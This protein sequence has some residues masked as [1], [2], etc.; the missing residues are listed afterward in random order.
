MN[1]PVP[2][3]SSEPA[4][5]QFPSE[6]LRGIA[7]TV[8]KISYPKRLAKL[9]LVLREW[10]QV[11]LAAHLTFYA[12]EVD[13]AKNEPLREKARKARQE[14]LKLVRFPDDVTERA[15]SLEEFP[16]WALAHSILTRTKKFA[17]HQEYQD[18]IDQITDGVLAAAIIIDAA[19]VALPAANRGQP[20]NTAAYLIMQDLEEIF[21]WLTGQRPTRLVNPDGLE[22]G[23]FFEF[24]HRIWVSTYGTAEG[25]Q[26]AIKNW[27]GAKLYLARL[28]PPKSEKSFVMENLHLRH[29]AWGL[30]DR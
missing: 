9:E 3:G 15:K 8:A 28:D 22:E 20:R 18:T 16:K 4:V 10:E 11:D 29:P 26:A 24:T 27:A 14:L 5:T 1:P 17:T 21:I 13:G 25:H 30:L 6:T 12:S 2:T 7:A 19:P 23:H